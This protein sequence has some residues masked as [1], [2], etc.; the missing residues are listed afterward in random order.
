MT[1][2]QRLIVLCALLHAAARFVPL[3]FL[4]DILR[5]RVRQ[6]LVSRLFRGSGRGTGKSSQ[7]PAL[8]RDPDSSCASGCASLVWR[9]PLAI[10]L[11]PIRKIVSLVRAIRGFSQDVTQSLFFGRG[12]ER[13]L[14]R[15]LFANDLPSDAIVVRRAF[16]QAIVG[17]DTQ[18]VSS[19]LQTALAGIKGLPAAALRAARSLGKR[20]ETEKEPEESPELERGMGAVAEVMARPD[21]ARVIA[22]F[23]ARFDSALPS[24]VAQNV[25]SIVTVD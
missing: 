14:G 25:S 1:P 18:L 21:V 7:V 19:A 2:V 6:Y 15:G 17:V 24:A 11:F 16:D 23:D 12:V 22:E 20:D 3:P 8:W 5:E 13:A 10:I 4:D 9:V